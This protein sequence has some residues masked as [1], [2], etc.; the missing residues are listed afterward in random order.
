[1]KLVRL[2]TALA[3]TVLFIAA[4]G[5]Q[6][7]PP[8]APEK[9]MTEERV[10]TPAPPPADTSWDTGGSVPSSLSEE[11]VRDPVTLQT[12]Y[13]DFDSSR[14]TDGGRDVLSQN[15]GWLKANPALNITVEGH[16][17]ERGTVEYNLALGERRAQSSKSYLVSL[18]VSKKRMF[19]I[20]YGKERP[21][22]PAHSEAAWAANRRCEFVV[23]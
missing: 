20:S 4:V 6:K 21:A 22:N 2:I 10:E 14:L 17:D 19:A 5:C 13:F 15:G 9:P 7:R 18:G 3:V 1:M 12:V 16:C 8:S 23:D 11:A